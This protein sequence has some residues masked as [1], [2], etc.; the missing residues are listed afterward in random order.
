M[1]KELV[2]TEQQADLIKVYLETDAKESWVSHTDKA[3]IS[4]I[5]EKLKEE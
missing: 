5:L 4:Q 2:L 3:I 1:V